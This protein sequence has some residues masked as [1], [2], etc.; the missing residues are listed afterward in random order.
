MNCDSGSDV[1]QEED[2][3]IVTQIKCEPVRENLKF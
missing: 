3:L 2:S 1:K